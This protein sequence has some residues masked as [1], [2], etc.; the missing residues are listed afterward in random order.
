MVLPEILPLT[1]PI[2]KLAS[3][4]QRYTVEALATDIAKLCLTES[5]VEKVVVRVE[6]PDAIETAKSAGVEITRTRQDFR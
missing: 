2:L 3:T 4:A 6:K 5:G 1:A